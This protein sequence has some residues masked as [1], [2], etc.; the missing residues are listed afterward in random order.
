MQEKLDQRL[1]G[2]LDALSEFARELSGQEPLP[3]N[4]RETGSFVR[5]RIN[6]DQSS[7]EDGLSKLVLALVDLIRQLLEKQAIR[8]IEAG[9]LT[10]D[11]IERMGETFLKIEQK[12]VDLK[13]ALGVEDE[14]LTLSLGSL[15]DL[16][17]E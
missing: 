6:A 13:T 4:G 2:D 16:I 14:D 8:R 15:R 12:M 9:S 10:D 1:R 5:Q 17:A 11:Q 3:P 7:V